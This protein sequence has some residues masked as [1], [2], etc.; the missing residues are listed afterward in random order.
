MSCE[1]V[2]ITVDNI[3]NELF[4]TWVKIMTFFTSAKPNDSLGQLKQLKE[5]LFETNVELNSVMYTT[6]K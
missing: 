5:C 6:N 3:C 1:I 2:F 4:K